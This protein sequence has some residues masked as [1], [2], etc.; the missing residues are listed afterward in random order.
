MT[1]EID[2][3]G[4]REP[5]LCIPARYQKPAK[6]Q[7][8][9]VLICNYPG[10]AFCDYRRNTATR[11]YCLL[12]QLSIPKT[13]VRDVYA[14]AVD[15]CRLVGSDEATRFETAVIKAYSDQHFQEML[16]GDLSQ[17]EYTKG[18]FDD[19]N[20]EILAYLSQNCIQ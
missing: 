10:N 14:N 2:N 5:N 15:L 19:L 6:V 20:F 17:E 1:E 7:G 11:N 18:M 9:D 16:T 3:E 4:S 13:E 12:G 8:H